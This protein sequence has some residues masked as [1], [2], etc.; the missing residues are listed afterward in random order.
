[1]QGDH[2][3]VNSCIFLLGLSRP[4][5]YGT[6]TFRRHSVPNKHDFICTTPNF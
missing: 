1:M 3:Y 5:M 2:G 4:D 6:E